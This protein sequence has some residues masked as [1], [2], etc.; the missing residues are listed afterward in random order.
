MYMQRLSWK[1]NRNLHRN[2]WSSCSRIILSRITFRT[3]S[4]RI[5]S[6]LLIY[7]MAYSWCDSLCSTIRTYHGR[8]LIRST[9]VYNPIYLAESA[10]AHH[11]HQF[12]MRYTDGYYIQTNQVGQLVSRSTFHTCCAAKVA[13][14]AILLLSPSSGLW[15]APENAVEKSPVRKRILK[16]QVEWE[17]QKSERSKKR[18]K[19]RGLF[20]WF[21]ISNSALVFSIFSLC[22][23]LSFF[24]SSSPPSCSYDLSTIVSYVLLLHYFDFIHPHPLLL[25]HHLF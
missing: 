17:S 14:R 6:S 16:D 20:F 11:T 23:C 24:S 2:G 1:A 5:H 18:K 3:A 9:E 21:F 7:F 15:L 13:K 10:S 8:W 22:F 4:S 25:H 19:G 12:E